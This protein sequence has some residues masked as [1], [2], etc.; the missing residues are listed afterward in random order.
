MTL[1][2]KSASGT[3]GLPTAFKAQSRPKRNAVVDS[4]PE[5]SRALLMTSARAATLRTGFEGDPV[6]L[7]DAIDALEPTDE[8]G[9]PGDAIGLAASL[10]AVSLLYQRFVF[11]RTSDSATVAG[12]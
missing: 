2:S 1:W 11:R 10:L 7:R 4:L 9:R 3:V 6:R 5:G 12:P 8:V